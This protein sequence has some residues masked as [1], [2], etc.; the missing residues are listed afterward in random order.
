MNTSVLNVGRLVYNN[1]AE[2]TLNKQKK[3]KRISVVSSVLYMSFIHRFLF[4]YTKTVIRGG[5][6][7][8]KDNSL[9]PLSV[10]TLGMDVAP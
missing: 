5:W 9:F 3:Q 2:C 4:K 7:D 6:V 1:G 10:A 8:L